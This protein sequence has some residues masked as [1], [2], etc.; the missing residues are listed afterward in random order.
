MYPVLSLVLVLGGGLLA[1]LAGRTAPGK[2]AARLALRAAGCLLALG[3]LA[4]L[5]LLL[6]GR[7]TPPLFR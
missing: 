5:A 7:V 1:A 4:A 6:S 3:G 2:R